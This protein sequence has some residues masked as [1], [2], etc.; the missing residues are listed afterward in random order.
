MQI[1]VFEG[2]RLW[3]GKYKMELMEQC[4]LADS[5]GAMGLILLESP[6]VKENLKPACRQKEDSESS[7]YISCFLIAF[8]L[9]Q[10]LCQRHNLG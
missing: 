8:S 3:G 5:S 9:K 6:P 10:F 2:R 1:Q 7:S 4:L